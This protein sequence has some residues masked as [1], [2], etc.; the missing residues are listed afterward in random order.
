[1]LMI[2]TTVTVK[3]HLD[4][5]MCFI[6]VPFDPKAVFGKMRASVKVTLNGH[7]YRSTIFSM[8]GVIGIPLRKSHREAAGVN[9]DETMAV[10]M[11]L[12]TEAREVE[13][14]EDLSEALKAQPGAWDRWQKLSFTHQR[15]HV[16][17]I[18]NAKKAE[19]RARRLA[20]TLQMLVEMQ[21]P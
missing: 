3:L 14:P 8:R 18:E 20:N 12:D 1:M 6:P 19:T 2:S 5:A 16:E 13:L 21:A 17:A 4:G 15:E 7:T 10:H 9:G 11:E